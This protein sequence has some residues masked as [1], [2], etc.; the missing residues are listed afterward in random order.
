MKKSNAQ[1]RKE[2]VARGLPRYSPNDQESRRIR[3]NRKNI[4]ERR[5]KIKKEVTAYK[6]A[7]G[8]TDCGY[9]IHPDALEFDHLP[10]FEKVKEIGVMIGSGRTRDIIFAE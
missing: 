10:G 5:I 7:H 6:L 8:C 1:Y 3:S 9:D 4:S 2:R